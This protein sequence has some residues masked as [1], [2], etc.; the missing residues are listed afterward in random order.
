MIM[1]MM[2]KAGPK[3]KDEQFLIERRIKRFFDRIDMSGH[4]WH[5][6][7]A[8]SKE[9]NAPIVLSPWTR[10]PTTAARVMYAV[11]CGPVGELDRIKVKCNTQWC[12]NP[13]HLELIKPG[14]IKDE[15]ANKLSRKPLF[16]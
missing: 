6:K 2:K 3:K 1:R 5:W 7:G 13:E 14:M 11:R 8:R 12:L 10:Q 4:C 15:K 16:S 9:S